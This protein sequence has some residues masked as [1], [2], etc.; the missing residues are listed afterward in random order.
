M[1]DLSEEDYESY[2]E[3]IR[4]LA[5]TLRQCFAAEKSRYYVVGHQ[6]TQI[7]EIEGLYELTKEEIT[8]VAERVLD[9]LDV[10]LDEISLVPLSG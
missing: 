4:I 5:D 9:E 3:D 2:E 10:D 1:A 6:N 7:I 8:E